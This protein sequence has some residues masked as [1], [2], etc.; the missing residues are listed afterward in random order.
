[1]ID[2]RTN[3]T[4]T[5]TQSAVGHPP[6]LMIGKGWFPEQLG[7]LNRYFRDLLEQMPEARALV[8]GPVSGNDDRVTA[9]SSHDA[10]LSKRLLALSRTSHEAGRG[11]AAVDA[12]FA[13]YAMLPILSR[14]L[15]ALPLIVHFHGP[16]ADENRVGDASQAR[17][18]LRGALERLVYRRASRVIVLSSAFRRVLVERYGVSP[19]RVEVQPPGV[20]LIQ[21]SPGDRGYARRVFGLE[22]DPFVAVA[23]RRLV[24]RM[25]LDVLL[26]AW[27]QARPELGVGARLLIAGDG[28]EREALESQIARLGL[29]DSVQ[30]VGRVNDRML[31]ELYRAADV[32]L[33][34]T[35]SFEGFGLVVIEAAACGTPSI[36]TRVGGLPEVV[37]ALDRSLVV[38]SNDVGALAMRLVAAAKSDLPERDDVRR[39][40]ER[41]SWEAAVE[42]N[43]RIVR[44]ALALAEP[45]R[46]M[47]VVY[48][49]HV[50]QLSG[51]EIALLRLLPHLEEV[52]PHVILAEDGPFADRLVQSGIST[53]VLPMH[54]G[55][56]DLRKDSVTARALRFGV[57]A[58]TAVHVLRLAVHLRRLS[59]DLVHANSLKSGLYGSLAA[60][61]AGVPM[62][63]HVRDCI[64][65]DYLPRSAVRLVRFMTRHLASA[66]VANS[67][68][69]AATI[70]PRVKPVVV[71]SVVSHAP[72]VAPIR[73]VAAAAEITVGMIG[74][75]A[76][77]KGQDLFVRAFAD[78]FPSGA[79]RCVLVGSAM[80]G[81]ED[82]VASLHQLAADLGVADR[83]EFRGFRSDVEHELSRFDMLV[84]ASIIPEPFGQVVLEGLGAGVPV[85][86]A[87]A[88][89]PAEI[90]RHEINGLLYPMGDQRAL[91]R[92][93]RRLADDPDERLRLAES[94]YKTASG[95][96]TEDVSLLLQD[97][98]R[99]AIR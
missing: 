35:R 41:F 54:A 49:D 23:V 47:R 44:E 51:G 45:C 31:V 9:A 13:L 38:A 15:R 18:L 36:V 22:G 30:M 53:E 89:G 62:V 28:V 74:R 73:R 71:Y 69:T 37:E 20:D 93:L 78:A 10:P 87:A 64:T 77:W 39:F 26:D 19:W 95:Y 21:F 82:Y 42:G 79:Q 90:L 70:D 67:H 46:R 59:P 6:V 76:P 1:M 16:W 48:L 60:R 52:D 97:V 24:T 29:S 88:G 65:E 75:L 43:R 91:S 81:E 63:W 99:A 68:A 2:R 3:V 86:A 4:A 17:Q 32:G 66:V 12:H 85:I 84:H 58:H 5:E 27:S 83:V 92:N 98:Y 96:R 11:I 80:F 50:G 57:L 55:A 61:L 7:G 25:G 33:V 8:V 40:A 34:P 94:G 56:R 72:R 14:R